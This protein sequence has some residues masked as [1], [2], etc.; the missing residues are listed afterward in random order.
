MNGDRACG[1]NRKLVT[2]TLDIPTE[3]VGPCLDLETPAKG[4]LFS[5]FLLRLTA[6]VQHKPN[7]L[8][9]N[10]VL[11]RLSSERQ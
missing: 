1:H 2:S 6:E 5:E 7:G 8:A 4:A 9:S 11:K 3:R 10:T